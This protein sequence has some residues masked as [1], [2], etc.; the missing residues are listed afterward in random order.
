[1]FHP[2]PRDSQRI[3][4]ESLSVVFHKWK[5]IPCSLGAQQLFPKKAQ[6]NIQILAGS[7]SIRTLTPECFSKNSTRRAAQDFPFIIPE[8]SHVRALQH[9]GILTGNVFGQQDTSF[10]C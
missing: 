5:Q 8:G 2:F 7:P 9:T 6:R 10:L 3:H 4:S 1:M